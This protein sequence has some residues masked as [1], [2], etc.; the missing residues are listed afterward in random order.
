MDAAMIRFQYLLVHHQIRHF[1]R[2]GFLRGR[3]EAILEF[4]IEVV[5]EIRIRI[6]ARLVLENV[7]V[8]RVVHNGFGRRRGAQPGCLF[9]QRGGFF[10]SLGT[11]LAT[12]GREPSVEASRE[13]LGSSTAAAR[14]KGA[15]QATGRAATV[16]AARRIR[17]AHLEDG[18]AGCPVGVPALRGR[19]RAA[20]LLFRLSTLGARLQ[21]YPNFIIRLIASCIAVF[22][23]FES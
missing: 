23:L 6:V 16:G 9:G 4:Q 14:K 1:C 5:A 19:G 8:G 18:R 21:I 10:V 17:A 11:V 7:I 3:A 15:D 12:Q 13:R 20:T 2:G 22:L